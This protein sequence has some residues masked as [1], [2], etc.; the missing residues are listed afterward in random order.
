M[1]PTECLD[2]SWAEELSHGQVCHP[3]ALISVQPQ[4]PRAYPILCG[5]LAR[6]L[7]HHHRER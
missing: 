6:P 7:K 1:S 3:S 5:I 4:H 2:M